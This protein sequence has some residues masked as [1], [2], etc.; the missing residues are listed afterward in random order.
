M[1][2]GGAVI[3]TDLESLYTKWFY[4]QLGIVETMG[5]KTHCRVMW[6]QPVKYFDSFTYFSDFP[7][8]SFEVAK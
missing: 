2:V 6:L 5:T 1:K 3:F 4:G 8:S 7:I